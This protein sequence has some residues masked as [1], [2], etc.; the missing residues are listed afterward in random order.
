[1]AC[2]RG[3]EE[4]DELSRAPPGSLDEVGNATGRTAVTRVALA[5]GAFIVAAALSAVGPYADIGQRMA[6]RAPFEE[7]PAVSVA[8]AV[9]VLERLGDAGRAAYARQLAVDVLVIVA[10]ATWLGLWLLAVGGRTFPGR[11][12]RVVPPALTLAPALADLAEDAALGLILRAHPTPSALLVATAAIATRVKL[13]MFV[14]AVAVALALT[15]LV[16]VR[17]VTRRGGS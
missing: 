7:H 5:A 4:F 13:V 12:A 15:V 14:V 10:N 3:Q 8:E 17:G 2:L 9:A 11:V 16:A 6:R 1:M